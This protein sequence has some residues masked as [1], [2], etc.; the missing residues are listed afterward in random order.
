MDTEKNPETLIQLIIAKISQLEVL[1]NCEVCGISTNCKQIES[2]KN[3]KS[4]PEELF[5]V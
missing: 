1:N 2:G 3:F 4:L 5:S